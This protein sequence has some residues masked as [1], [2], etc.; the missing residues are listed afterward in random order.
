MELIPIIKLSVVVFTIVAGFVITLSYM[1]YK[2]RGN[3]KKPW[4][5]KTI[6]SITRVTEGHTNMVQMAAPTPAF[7][8]IPTYSDQ[9]DQAAYR[10]V[11]AAQPRVVRVERPRER[12]KVVNNQQVELRKVNYYH[13]QVREFQPS[14]EQKAQARAFNRNNVLSSYASGNDSLKKMSLN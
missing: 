1:M 3:D 11:Q 9:M 6:Q 13:S 5:R 14:A 2:L 7:V 10:Q 4:L 8:S 12:F